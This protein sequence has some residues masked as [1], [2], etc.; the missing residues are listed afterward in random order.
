MSKDLNMDALETEA[1]VAAEATTKREKK[2]VT[3]EEIAAL[4]KAVEKVQEFGVSAEYAQVMRMVPLWHDT[5]ANAAIKQEVIEFFGDSAKLKDYIDGP[6]VEEHAV[7]SGLGKVF[8][9]M[10]NIKSFY[11]RREGTGKPRVKLTS[12]NIGGEF[13]NVS[14]DYLASLSEVPNAE[15]RELL[16]AHESTKKNESI[17]VL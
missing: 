15:K 10:N 8:S 9:T 11:A 3:A 13:Y 14:A 16:L 2:V 7:I 5:E 6:F 12:V 4:E 1:T 17:E